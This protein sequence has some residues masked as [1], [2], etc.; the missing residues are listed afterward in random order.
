[1]PGSELFGAEERKEVNDVLETGILFRY[2]HDNLRNGHWKAKEFE[3]E[4][5]KFTGA[6]YAHTC[7]SGST[8]VAIAMACCGIGAGDEVIVPPFTYIATV[9]GALL[10]GAVP[11]FAEI[12][13][14]LCL[15]PEGIR[16][17]LTPRTKAVVLVHM[18]GSMARLDEIMAICEEHNLLL[19]EDSAQALGATYK[20]KHVGLFGKM[21]CFSFDFFKIIT[22]GEGGAVITND[23]VLYDYAHQYSDHGHDH[24]GDNR[25]AEQHPIVG[26][27]YR[28]GELN[29][30]VGL[31]Q[32]RK[33]PYI[34]EQQR[35][36]KKI[37]HD[38]LA[39][40][41]QISFRH[42]P[43]PAGDAAT[44]IDF[45]LPD[46]ATTRK[47][48]QAFQKA[49]IGVQYWYDNNFHYIKNWEHLREMKTIAKVHA[50]TLDE[51]PQDYR[52]IHLNLPKTDEVMRRLLSMVVRVTWTEDELK[53][54]TQQ[55]TAVLRE[56]LA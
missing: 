38:C 37:L 32:A 20:G 26:F 43:D 28:M 3:A 31:A 17:A 19:I 35:K 22:A 2:N 46:E 13:E 33:L 50:Q 41:P 18:C 29:A 5:A 6:K 23:P 15:S 27:N 30:A 39:Q 44:F 53:A 8:A 16:A 12:D 21:G 7:T 49:S 54:F 42:I 55:L 24:I 11:V 47:V 48:Q 34:I 52:T 14:T 45:F 10:G 40:F 51:L 9:E 1:M 56:A 25:G 36:H 4:L